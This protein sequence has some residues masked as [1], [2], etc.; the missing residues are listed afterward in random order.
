MRVEWLSVAARNHTSQLVVS[1]TPFVIVYRIEGKVII[2]LR[3]LH[4]AQQWPPA[5]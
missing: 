3:L 5:S 4:G 2:I 1:S